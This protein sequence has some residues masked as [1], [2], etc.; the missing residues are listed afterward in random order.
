MN[1]RVRKAVEHLNEKFQEGGG[2]AFG[3]VSLTAS[4]ICQKTLED[5]LSIDGH[6]AAKEG[7]VQAAAIDIQSLIDATKAAIEQGNADMAARMAWSAAAKFA[8]AEYKFQ[9]KAAAETGRKTRKHLK[10]LRDG[11]N[12]S[13]KMRAEADRQKWQRCA[14]EIWSRRPL[15]SKRATADIVKRAC[16]A[17]QKASTIRKAI[18][19]VGTPS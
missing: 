3:T 18:K 6:P 17:R 4:K 2:T 1:D 5:T 19:K 12:Q 15:L 8:M 10:D 9:W 16:S 7:S 14:E 11:Q 13:E